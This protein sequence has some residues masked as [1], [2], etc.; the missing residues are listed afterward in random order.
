MSE[1]VI[2]VNLYTD[3]NAKFSLLV[4][5]LFVNITLYDYEYFDLKKK[6]KEKNVFNKCPYSCVFRLQ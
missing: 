2:I 1:M 5:V 6:K 3:L 4:T